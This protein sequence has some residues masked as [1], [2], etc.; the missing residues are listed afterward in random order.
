M[1]SWAIFTFDRMF[2]VIVLADGTATV[3]VADRTR[4]DEKGYTTDLFVQKGLHP[5]EAIRGAF[6]FCRMHLAR[7]PGME[8]EAIRKI[9]Y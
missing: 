7:N 8:L 3:T 6:R 5:R 9:R 4:R 2:H 1:R